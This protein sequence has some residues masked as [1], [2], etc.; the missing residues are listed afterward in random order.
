MSGAR[1]LVAVALAGGV[2]A[3]LRYAVGRL[4]DAH[5]WPTGT[6]LVNLAGSALLGALVGGGAP[7]ALLAVVGT[8]F[9]GGLTT[10]SSFA[11][12]TVAL[13]DTTTGPTAGRRRAAAYALVTVVG[14]LL[15]A[16]AGWAGT[17]SLVG[18]S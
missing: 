7:A 12:Q 16:T 3:G 8:G 10:Y 17:S 13:V 9:C 2:G 15:A 14:C 18:T 11:V 5:A 1:L 4:L 6:L